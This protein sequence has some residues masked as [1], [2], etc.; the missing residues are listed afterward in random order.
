MRD[1]DNMDDCDVHRFSLISRFFR[2][3]DDVYKGFE[4]QK[5]GIFCTEWEL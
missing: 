1:D 5:E 4:I 3:N 2:T